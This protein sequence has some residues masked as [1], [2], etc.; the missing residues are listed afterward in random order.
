MPVPDCLLSVD[1]SR[2]SQVLANIISNSYKYAGTPIDVSYA[3]D[4]QFLAMSLTDHGG[5]IPEE[6]LAFITQKY[7]RGR[8]NSD[9]KEGSGLGLYISRALTEKM[10]GIFTCSNAPD[11]LTVTLRLPLSH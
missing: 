2:L 9:G 11:G 10:Q 5:G 4:G 8:Q 6:E 7:Y 3:F 1:R